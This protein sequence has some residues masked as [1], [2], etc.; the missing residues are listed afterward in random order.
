MPPETPVTTPDA[1]PIVATEG[2]LLVHV[3]PVDVLLKVVV[4]PAHTTATPEIVDGKEF[5]VTTV[6]AVQVPPKV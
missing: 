6:V 5:I 1:E 3:P 4:D 2:L